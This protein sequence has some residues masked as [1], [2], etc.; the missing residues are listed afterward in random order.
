MARTKLKPKSQ[1]YDPWSIYQAIQL[2]PEEKAAGR[3]EMRK[4]AEEAA[5]NGAYTRFEALRGRVHLDVDFYTRLREE[6]D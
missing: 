3:E 5:R 1:G 6:D 4:A 2:T